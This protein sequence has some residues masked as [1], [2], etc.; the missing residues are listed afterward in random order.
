MLQALQKGGKMLELNPRVDMLPQP[1]P[2]KP[3]AYAPGLPQP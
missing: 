2:A 1:D 3:E